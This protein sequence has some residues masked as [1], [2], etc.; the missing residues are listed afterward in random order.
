MK[1]PQ[2]PL[3]D[4][5]AS[6]VALA[7]QSAT[8]TGEHCPPLA[9][10]GHGGVRGTQLPAVALQ[11]LFASVTLSSR[12]D[13]RSNVSLQQSTGVRNGQSVPFTPPTPPSQ[14][15]ERRGRDIMPTAKTAASADSRPTF[16]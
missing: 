2:F 9:K 11:A 15:G 16:V 7:P 10:G 6:S 4:A 12:V 5:P 14:G 13:V 8:R 1:E 3:T